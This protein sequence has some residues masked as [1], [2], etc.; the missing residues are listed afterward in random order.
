MTAL[1]LRLIIA[2]IF[3][4]TLGLFS[5]AI[6]RVTG[7]KKTA[8]LREPLQEI[9]VTGSA[10]LSTAKDIRAGWSIGPSDECR[11]VSAK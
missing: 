2:A 6:E 5:L 4:G 11:V 9:T 10:V 8:V 7:N 1:L 3:A